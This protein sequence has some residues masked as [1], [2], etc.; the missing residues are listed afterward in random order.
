MSIAPVP[1]SSV[2]TVL[3][4]RDWRFSLRVTAEDGHLFHEMVPRPNRHANVQ[5][6]RARLV[7]RLH[8]FW[9]TT[10]SFQD[11]EYQLARSFR[12]PKVMYW[13]VRIEVLSMRSF[14]GQFYDK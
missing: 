1:K 14:F 5:R 4:I 7:S 8:S 6:D 13:M 2:A 12:K 10:S 11:R 3:K 9:R